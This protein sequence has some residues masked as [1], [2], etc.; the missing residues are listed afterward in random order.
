MRKFHRFS[1]AATL[2]SL[3]ALLTGCA[4]PFQKRLAE[5]KKGDSKAQYDVALCYATGRGTGPDGGKADPAPAEAVRWLEESADQDNPEAHLALGLFYYYHDGV[6]GDWDDYQKAF[7]HIDKA[8]TWNV[9][10]A[11]YWLGECYLKGR[12]I[13]QDA[14]KAIGCFRA[15]A[16]GDIGKAPAQAAASMAKM[17]QCALHGT[18]CHAD[19]KES[20]SWFEKAKAAGD[21][22]AADMLKILTQDYFNEIQGL[23]DASAEYDIEESFLDPAEGTFS[24]SASVKEGQDKSKARD[25][26]KEKVRA[27]CENDLAFRVPG[28]DRQTVSWEW[29]TDSLKKD[30]K[31]KLKLAWAYLHVIPDSGKYNAMTRIGSLEFDTGNQTGEV[32]EQYIANEI[33]AF[34]LTKLVAVKDGKIQEGTMYREFSDR[35]EYTGPDKRLLRVEFKVLN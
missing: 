18:G 30:G 21:K 20:V 6:P 26:L 1:A 19:Y 33:N 12:G 9:P 24:V 29:K 11:K 7:A 22:G 31:I 5:A 34:C 17:G 10:G 15:S 25:I 8:A 2:V 28:L 32:L 14:V 27:R 23:G 16:S 4:T 35:R 13:K 3:A